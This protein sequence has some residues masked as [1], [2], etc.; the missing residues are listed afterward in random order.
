M[1]EV[2]QTVLD[3][4]R[5]PQTDHALLITG[6]WGCGKTYF[7]KNVLVPQLE[8]LKSPQRP[9][10]IL[11]ASLY[12]VSD[13]KDIDRSLFVQS[14]PGINRK[15]VSRISRIVRGFVEALGYVDLAKVNLRSLVKAKGAVICFDD[16]E[17]TRL[18]MKEA[19]GYINTFV[20]HEGAKTVILCN[21]E[22]I[23]D[24]EARK[25]YDKMKEKVVGAS[26][27]FQPDLDV[28]FHTLIDEQKPRKEFH[29]FI[30]Q[31]AALVGQLFSRSETHNIRSLRRAIAAFGVIFEALCVGKV[32]PGAIAT[33]LIYAVA[34][35]AFEL[36]GRGADPVTI[37]KI[38][39][40]NYM[41]M[42]GISLSNKRR[43]KSKE[44]KYEEEFAERYFRDFGMVDLMSVTG[45]P[46][47]CEFLITGFL[48]REALLEWAMELTRPPDEKKE[49]IKRLLYDPRQME[50][51]EFNQMASQ[52]LQEVELGEIAEVG[53]YISLYDRFEW[54]SD[55]NLI[56]MTRQ[57]V[58]KKFTDGLGIAQ[59]NGKL[60]PKPHLK[61]EISHPAMAPRTDE[62]R[63]LH[64]HALEVNEKILKHG[65]CE[66]IRALSS[67]FEEDAQEFIDALFDDGESGL[68]F[69]PVFQELDADAAAGRILAFPNALKS[70]FGMAMQA[71]YGKHVL[72]SEF[73]VELPV[74]TRIRDVMKK[75]CEDSAND[76]GPMSMNLFVTQGI[77]EELSRT[78]EQLQ[79]LKQP[80]EGGKQ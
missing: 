26:L 17:R 28:V 38:L 65:V 9:Q 31:N 80:E 77:V 74:L 60:E 18:S 27:P 57:E 47:I 52:V 51:E 70:H 58:L 46:P 12:G 10:R 16:L 24:E 32:D 8:S 14:Y 40:M 36:Y 48:D 37:R 56:S 42:A 6:P 34:P 30:S 62:C 61:L 44:E 63:I 1:N 20:E 39:G 15:G 66:R 54:F 55:Q 4:V 25:T 33:Q 49:R 7:W 59:E 29:S 72:P 79:Q 53:T 22:A 68:L 2:L 78:I 41:A 71:R 23:T 69:T 76:T 13:V 35:T 50:D 21:E 5:S 67:R 45:C 43:E 11:Y 73:A 3:Y 75:H 19:L 64:Q